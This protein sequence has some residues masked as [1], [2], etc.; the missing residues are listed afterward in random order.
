VDTPKGKVY[1]MLPHE[2]GGE[3]ERDLNL[4]KATFTIGPE[5]CPNQWY[6]CP[7]R[8]WWLEDLEKAW[9][10]PDWYAARAKVSDP[11]WSVKPPDA[12]ESR[13]GLAGKG[14]LP[15]RLRTGQVVYGHQYKAATPPSVS[16][17]A[18]AKA[19]DFDRPTA[20]TAQEQK[21]DELSSPEIRQTS[22]RD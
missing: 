13:Y 4:C 22:T 11:K 8:H 2:Y 10:K 21:A 9:V 19:A 20:P 5:R 18:T 16:P 12:F 15:R 14:V 3:G 7:M 1:K 6:E 17:W